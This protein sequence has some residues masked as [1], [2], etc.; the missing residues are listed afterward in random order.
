MQPQQIW[1][2]LPQYLK[3]TDIKTMDIVVSPTISK[4]N[5]DPFYLLRGG[6]LNNTVF[7]ISP[8]NL[9]DTACPTRED[10]D[11]DYTNRH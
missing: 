10:Q 4:L 1:L 9:F 8:K 5:K 3:Y 11:E 6:K 2:K 7:S